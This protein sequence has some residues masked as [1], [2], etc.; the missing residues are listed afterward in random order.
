MTLIKDSLLG[1]TA[2]LATLAA[3]AASATTYDFTL[4]D[5]NGV[6]IDASGVLN[7]TGDV[8]NNIAGDITGYGAITGLIGNPNSPGANIVGDI[9]YDNLFNPSVPGVDNNGIYVSTASGANIN[10]YNVHSSGSNIPDNTAT[11]YVDQVGSVANGTFSV[12]PT[13][14]PEPAGWA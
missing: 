6:T 13:G 2:A 8:I 14:V 11:V 1:A 10:L 4:L 3:T 5:N 9:L 7:L 12:S